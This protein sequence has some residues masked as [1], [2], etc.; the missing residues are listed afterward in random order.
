M[1]L[2]IIVSLLLP[3]LI[4]P[5]LVIAG[6]MLSLMAISIWPAIWLRHEDVTEAELEEAR[7]LAADRRDSQ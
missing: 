4:Y 2:E 7:R 6:A 1:S 5:C 3:N